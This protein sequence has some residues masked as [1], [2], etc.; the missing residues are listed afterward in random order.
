V[1]KLLVKYF[2][3]ANPCTA[4][5]SSGPHP[6]Y[7][8]VPNNTYPA[9]FLFTS[10]LGRITLITVLW[11]LSQS[12][13]LRNVTAVSYESLAMKYEL[14]AMELP[15]LYRLP[16]INSSIYYVA[17]VFIIYVCADH[18]PSPVK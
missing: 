5:R 13:T 8:L 7:L 15:R 9:V 14:Y 16:L 1:R 4:A 3:C 2:S 11:I 18:V 10:I 6:A 12:F 17:F